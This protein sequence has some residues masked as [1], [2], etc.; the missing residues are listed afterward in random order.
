M[1][2]ARRHRR[3]EA[4]ANRKVAGLPDAK[5][6]RPGTELYPADADVAFT[7][8]WAPDKASCAEARRLT[9]DT[10][11]RLLGDRRT[12]GVAWSEGHGQ[13]ALAMCDTMIE[14]A[15]SDELDAYTEIRKRLV[16]YGGYIVIAHCSGVR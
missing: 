7:P 8:A 15:V 11:I 10:L 14:G 13:E 5:P 4:R 6:V 3:R 12:S 2:D 1:S 9:H 16:A